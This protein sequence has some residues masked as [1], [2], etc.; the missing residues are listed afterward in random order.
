MGTED[1][2]E[3]LNELLQ[4]KDVFLIVKLHP[5]QN[6]KTVN[7]G[8]YSNI[9]LVENE[10][11]VAHDIPVNRLL[12]MADALISD[13]SSAAVDYMLMDRPIAFMLEDVEEYEQSR[14]FVF[15]NIR[16]WLP[17]KEI[18]CFEEICAF[19]EEVAAGQDKAAEKRRMLRQKMHR[20]CDDH[21]CRRILEALEI[22]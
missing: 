2:L 12:G 11:L 9:R 13:Y 1:K 4:I 19:V 14:G 8:E 7:C 15:D 21:S 3:R 16:E 20:F 10:E 22:I 6:R 18:F 17:G 5:F